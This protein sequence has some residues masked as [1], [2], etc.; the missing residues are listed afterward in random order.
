[1]TSAKPSAG[2]AAFAETLS[3]KLAL[4][5][6]LDFLLENARRASARRELHRHREALAAQA[7]RAVQRVEDVEFRTLVDDGGD[8]RFKSYAVGA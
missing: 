7:Q 6:R 8:K 2:T 1:L 4:L 3:A 5:E